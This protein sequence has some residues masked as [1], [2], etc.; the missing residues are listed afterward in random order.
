MPLGALGR[1]VASL[2]M[3]AEVAAVV[4]VDVGLVVRRPMIKNHR[5]PR[6][7]SLFPSATGAIRSSAVAVDAPT[8]FVA[9][10]K[11]LAC[12]RSPG[13]HPEEETSR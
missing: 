13:Q 12:Y 3:R 4:A 11:T 2:S 6:I 8:C 5:N 7:F 10:S 9:P 1:F